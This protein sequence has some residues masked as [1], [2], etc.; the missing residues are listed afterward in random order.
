MGRHDQRKSTGDSGAGEIGEVTDSAEELDLSEVSPAVLR[1]R[2]SAHSDGRDDRVVA[3]AT[4]LRASLDRLA[5]GI[6]Y[7]REALVVRAGEMARA[8][9]PFAG[10]ALAA[11]IGAV[12]VLRRTRRPRQR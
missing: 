7:R 10:G 11:G 5:A 9:V 3:A 6:A 8:A 4:E 1:D 12:L 2:L